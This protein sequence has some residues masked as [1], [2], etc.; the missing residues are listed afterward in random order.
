[1]LVYKG[2]LQL[3]YN[4]H[5]NTYG[6]ICDKHG[7]RFIPLAFDTLGRMHPDSAKLL[8]KAFIN[9]RQG[10]IKELL[11]ARN[12]L[13]R[14]VGRASHASVST[15]VMPDACLPGSGLCNAP[16]HSAAPRCGCLVAAAKG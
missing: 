8:H 1:M 10:L 4:N 2:W 12:A 16:R 14:W 5:V 6:N 3:L 9:H 11:P 7:L 13:W 15:A